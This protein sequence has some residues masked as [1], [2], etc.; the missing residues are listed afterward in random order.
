MK[1]KRETII[2]AVYLSNHVEL[3]A[4]A[5]SLL[6]SGGRVRRKPQNMNTQLHIRKNIQ[7][8]AERQEMERGDS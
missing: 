1:D 4:R 2:E 5:A 3:K 7:K 6:K 8:R